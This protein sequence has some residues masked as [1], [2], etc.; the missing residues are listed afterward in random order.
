MRHERGSRNSPSSCGVLALSSCLDAAFVTY[1]E[2]DVVA[3]IILRVDDIMVASC[4]R[5]ET[6]TVVST[7]RAQ[8]PLGEWLDVSSNKNG[9]T[10]TGRRSTT[11]EDG[12]III[13]QSE[14][15]KARMGGL[16][17]RR[18][19]SR[20]EECPCMPS[21]HADYRCAAGSLRWVMSETRPSLSISTSTLQKAQSAPCWGNYKILAKVVQ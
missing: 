13:G 9:V 4:G 18:G 8:Y 12:I 10:F 1:I 17:V 5:V 2:K 6:E 16:L 19:D 21:E 20:P 14:F 3:V 11:T 7:I 15:V